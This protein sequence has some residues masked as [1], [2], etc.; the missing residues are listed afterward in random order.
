MNRCPKCG[1][2]WKDEGRAK[3]G[4]RR[5]K[6][7]KKADRSAIMKAVRA[8]GTKRKSNDSGLRSPDRPRAG[9]KQDRVV[10]SLNQEAKG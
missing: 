8:A 5:W 2:E 7:S 6:G 1:Y 10:G 3:G 9:D 4:A